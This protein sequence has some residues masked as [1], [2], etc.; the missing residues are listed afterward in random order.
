MLFCCWKFFVYIYI[1]CIVDIAYECLWNLYSGAK[2]VRNAE[3]F[4]VILLL[5]WW[6]F[7]FMCYF[8]FWNISTEVERFPDSKVHGA[9]MGPTWVL[10]APGGPHVGPTNLAIRVVSLTALLSL[11]ELKIVKITT[12]FF[13]DSL[14][15][16][17][18]QEDLPISSLC[19]ILH[20]ANGPNLN[21][22]MVFSGLGFPLLR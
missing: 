1:I 13:F 10:S 16:S 15:H 11:D 2:L 9:N 8:I 22:K 20:S 6:Y 19:F 3:L 18:W 14:T 5:L 12:F 4:T 17:S 21:V 7:S